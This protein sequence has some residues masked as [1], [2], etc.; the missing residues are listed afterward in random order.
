MNENSMLSNYSRIEQAVFYNKKP[1]VNIGTRL[2]DHLQ[3]IRIFF[4][5]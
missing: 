4:M 2:H 3:K 1:F 5:L